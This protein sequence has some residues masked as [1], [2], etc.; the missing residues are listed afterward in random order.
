MHTTHIA[1]TRLRVDFWV[2]SCGILCFSEPNGA[3]PALL[4]VTLRGRGRMQLQVLY[5]RNVW[6]LG[7]AVCAVLRGCR[8]SPELSLLSL[9][10][11]IEGLARSARA[12]RVCGDGGR[13]GWCRGRGPCE[14]PRQIDR[15][16]SAAQEGERSSD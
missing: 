9:A 7:R 8:G 14:L 2:W 13:G 10:D 15:S 11:G 16:I 12:T 3:S 6:G 1:I 4:H 5:T